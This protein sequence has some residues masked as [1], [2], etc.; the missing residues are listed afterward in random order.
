MRVI[1]AGTFDPS[2]ERNQ[3]LFAL[4]RAG[5]HDVM[6]CNVEIWGSNRY[7][8]LHQGKASALARA[9]T[10][11]PKLAWRFVRSGRGDVVLVLYPGWFDMF[12]VGILARAR[13]IPVVFDPFISLSDTVVSDRKLV[14]ERSLIARMCRLVDRVSLGLATRVLADTPE[15]GELYARLGQIAPARIGVVPVGADETV[16]KPQPDVVAEPRRVLF[17]GTYIALHG[18]PTIIA[19]AKQLEADGITVRL[20]GSG[21]EQQTVDRLLTDLQPT[22]VDTIEWI[23]FEQ[24]PREIA[25]ATLCLGIFGTTDKARR[26][27]PNKVFQCLAVGRPVLTG[28]TP[29]IR[30]AFTPAQVAT[31]ATGD[32]SALAHTIR[33]LVYDTDAREALARAG[34]RHF[35][36]AF[37]SKTIGHALDTELQTAVRAHAG[38]NR[39]HDTPARHNSRPLIHTPGPTRQNAHLAA[40]KPST[41]GHTARPR[42]PV[43]HRE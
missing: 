37:S 7:A 21:Q 28:D 24:L 40:G 33:H 18:L 12:I 1:A 4:L 14:T 5:G 20:I 27:I 29:A 39:G 31:S 22:N 6:I 10:A 32:A 8:I 16:F 15:H 43:R 38:L 2:F 30:T 36:E 13:R 23:P 11:Y 9:L 26:V 42:S 19:A 35:R 3:R 25:S 41:S 34:H 17:Y